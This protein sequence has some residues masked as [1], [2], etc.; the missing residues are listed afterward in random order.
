MKDNVLFNPPNNLGSLAMERHKGRAV[1]G[2]GAFEWNKLNQIEWDVMRRIEQIRKTCL[3]LIWNLK[4]LPLRYIC[5]QA[6]S[7]LSNLSTRPTGSDPTKRRPN[8][9]KMTV[10]TAPPGL[11]RWLFTLSGGQETL[12]WWKL[13]ND[14]VKA[15]F[16][17]IKT[18]PTTLI[19]F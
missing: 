16:S 4:L 9:I 8:G 18:S 19:I 12:F 3:Q 5:L 17:L 14:P 7:L 2:L 11:Q 10:T 1:C 6:R 13:S 15:N